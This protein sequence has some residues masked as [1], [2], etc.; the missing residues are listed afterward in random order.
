MERE[1]ERVSEREK[2]RIGKRDRQTEPERD[3]H[4]ETFKE[5]DRE[6]GMGIEEGG[7]RG[8]RA[9]EAHEKM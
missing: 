7:W 6:K 9:K 3:R 8:R 5:T 2:A 1:R 4:R